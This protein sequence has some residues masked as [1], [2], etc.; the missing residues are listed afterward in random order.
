MPTPSNIT[1]PSFS[2]TASETLPVTVKIYSGSKV[3]GSPV[4]TAEGAVSSEKW[5]PVSSSTV[6]PSGTYTAVAVEQ[7]SLGNAPGESAPVTFVVNTKPPEVA[8]EPPPPARSKENK[9]TFKGTASEA[10][11]VTVHVYKGTE[12]KGEEAAKPTAVVAGRQMVGDRPEHALRTANTRSRRPSR[13][14]SGTPP[15]RANRR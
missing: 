3:E 14:R 8:I 4:A 5:G 6:L 1:K 12:A 7:S 2:G 13:A 10:G 15:A 11:T 9:P